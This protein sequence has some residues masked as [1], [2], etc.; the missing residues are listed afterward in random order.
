MKNKY[1]YILIISIVINL[2][3]I[4]KIISFSINDVTIN[5][6]QSSVDQRP[7]SFNV[8]DYFEKNRISSLNIKKVFNDN[9]LNN[10]KYLQEIINYS[11]KFSHDSIEVEKFYI[12]DIFPKLLTLYTLP[13]YDFNSLNN[14]LNAGIKFKNASILISEKEMIFSAFAEMIFEEVSKKITQSQEKN[15]NLSNRLDFQIL[16]NKCIENNF[17][18]DLKESSSDKFLKTL[19][20]KDYFHLIN[21][22]YQKSSFYQKIVLGLMFIFM[23]MGFIFFIKLIKK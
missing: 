3:F 5:L 4:F 6:N 16:V 12:N 20:E 8:E 23:I 1:S 9:L 15:T 2:Y 22:G 13:S 11:Y 19:L 14:L 17:Y 10:P 18:P 21:T 7:T